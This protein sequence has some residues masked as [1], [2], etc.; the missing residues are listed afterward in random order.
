MDLTKNVVAELKAAGVPVVAVDTVDQHQ[1]MKMFCDGAAVLTERL[2]SEDKWPVGMWTQASGFIFAKEEDAKLYESGG[3]ELAP[4]SLED[5][6]VA[7]IPKLA[8]VPNSTTLIAG[9]QS[10]T[11]N[12][13][14]VQ[15]ILDAREPLEG[16][17]CSIVLVGPGY[18][19]PHGLINSAVTYEHPLPSREELSEIITDTMAAVEDCPPLSMG[20]FERA[21]DAVHGLGAFPAKQVVALAMRP[22]GLDI[23]SMWARKRQF[24]ADTPSLSLGSDPI[25]FRDVG[26]MG[27]IKEQISD[28]FNGRQPPNLVVLFDEI[29][30]LL[31]GAQ[32]DT[33]G[34]A[35]DQLRT[36][37]TEIQNM[38]KTGSAGKFFVG[39]PGTAKTMVAEAAANTFGVPFVSCDTGAAKG[40]LVGESEAKIRGAFAVIK[41][42]SSGQALFIA[43][44]N[45]LDGIPPELRRRFPDGMYFFDL[46]DKEQR[47]IIWDLYLKKYELDEQERP[48][49][50]GWTGAEIATCCR[51]SWKVNKSLVQVARE[52]IVPVSVS[53]RATVEALRDLANDRF[54]DAAAGG[55]YYKDKNAS[56]GRRINIGR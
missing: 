27:G 6:A 16:N 49:D 7:I 52:T 22:G 28:L 24:I 12:S 44:C 14:V 20:D 3:V 23:E 37:L 1:T 13:L 34:V 40:S 39:P 42:M 26:G 15:A 50:H 51:R 4:V 41:A 36:M 2:G 30:K 21:I 53:S 9:A 33:S 43:T 11:E 17:G 56:S 38:L 54:L 31:S 47:D 55:K 18:R 8:S 19:P 5:C 10:V 45:K 25:V 29:D 48:D 35:Q 32:G 46:P